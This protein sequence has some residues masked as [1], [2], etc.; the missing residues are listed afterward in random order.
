MSYKTQLS[1]FISRHETKFPA[2]CAA[3]K[4]IAEKTI[5]IREKNCNS[6]PLQFFHVLNGVPSRKKRAE[7]SRRADEEC[8]SFKQKKLA[9]VQ[10][11]KR[12]KNEKKSYRDYQS[13]FEIGWSNVSEPNSYRR[14]VIQN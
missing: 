3:N 11:R 13:S 2:H 12:G 7:K 6:S 5:P 10:G 14:C 9:T 8:I 1:Y 4:A